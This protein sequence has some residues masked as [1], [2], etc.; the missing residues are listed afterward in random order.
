MRDMQSPA[1]AVQFMGAVLRRVMVR[2]EVVVF[3]IGA[4]FMGLIG[5]LY[6]IQ[7]INND[8]YERLASRQHRGVENLEP[9][10]GRIYTSDGRVLASSLLVDS[11]YVDSQFVGKQTQTVLTLRRALCLSSTTASDVLRRIQEGRRFIWVKRKVSEKEKS[12]LKKLKIPGVFFAK[13]H[14][15]YYP[16]GAQAAQVAG[17]CDIDDKGLAGVELVYDRYLRGAR[18]RRE[19]ERDACGRKI[20]KPG[21]LDMPAQNGNHIHITIDSVIQHSVEE[22]LDDT[23][24]KWEP[25]WVAAIV[26][27]VTNGEI[28]AMGSRPTFDPNK[29]GLYSVRRR[30]NYAIADMYEPGS[31]FKP[32]TFGALFEEQ[33]VNLD[34]RVFCEEGEA[35]IGRRRIHD[36]KPHGWLTVLDVIAKSSNIATAKCA[37]LMEELVFDSYMRKFGFSSRTGID[38]PAEADGNLRPVSQWSK[39]SLVSLAMGQEIG[40]T[41]LQV[42]CAFAAIA[43][44]GELYRPHVLKRIVDEKGNVIFQPGEHL[45]RRVISERTSADLKKAMTEVVETGT[46]TRVKSDKYMIAGKTGTAQK[47][48]PGVPGYAPNKYVGSFCGFAPV[49]DPKICVIVVVN[50]PHGWSHFGGTVAGPAVKEIIEKTLIHM[51]IPGDR[52]VEDA[53]TVGGSTQGRETCAVR[54]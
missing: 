46:G 54:R 6:R 19:F 2:G 26:L 3:I 50:E 5:R 52:K 31:T 32:I 34:T 25:I 43:N 10:R 11:V 16:E 27:D 1:D 23:F 17:F 15:R 36:H 14:K 12:I 28:L 51:R 44:G 41:A 30:R 35:R 8:R 4:L 9:V 24:E 39:Y 18:G 53:D 37:S 47:Q 49:S 38:L 29:P 22:A 42:A 40:V 21:M 13:E 33:L 7:Q 20:T 48:I 45:V